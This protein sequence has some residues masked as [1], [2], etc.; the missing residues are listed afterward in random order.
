MIM[1]IQ[2]YLSCTDLARNYSLLTLSHSPLPDTAGEYEFHEYNINT[3]HALPITESKLA[4]FNKQTKAHPTLQNVIKV[5]QTGWPENKSNILMK[6]H[7][8]M[9]SFLKEAN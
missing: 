3:P 9:A 5:V 4:E 2:R 1:S 6:S 7:I 8:M